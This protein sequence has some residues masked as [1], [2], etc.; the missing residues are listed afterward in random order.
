MT[1]DDH[2]PLRW[3]ADR[4]DGR[5]SPRRAAVAD[6]HLGSGCRRC[7]QRAR[8]L[9]R[10]VRALAAAEPEMPP[11][12]E[13]IRA[14][15]LLAEL[16][17]PWEEPAPGFLDGELLLDQRMELAAALRSA[18]GE[19]RRLLWAFGRY[20]LDASVV[21]GPAGA[22]LLGQV[23]PPGDD[24]AAQVEGRVWAIAHG[25]RVAE[26][27][28][29]QDGRFTFRRMP[30]GACTIEG[31]IQG[32]IDGNVEGVRFRLPPLVVE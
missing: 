22:D 27:A 16:R 29:A 23:V 14:I 21:T 9:D 28:L 13:E 26:A 7:E 32:E 5:L 18:P 15:A 19:A 30:R 8:R 31:E 6:A 2:L 20:E 12:R 4:R 11:E 1:R 3:L 10:I 24:P 25:A 17:P